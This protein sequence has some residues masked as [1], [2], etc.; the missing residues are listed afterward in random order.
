MFSAVDREQEAR[1]LG[2][3]YG[4][5]LAAALLLASRRPGADRALT[6]QMTQIVLREID[7]AVRKLRSGDFPAG[8]T[9]IYERGAKEGVRDM[10]LQTRAV[11]A[12][13]ANRAA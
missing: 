6:R 11:A 9:A 4:H 2:R 7:A 10:L 12:P 8:L 3:E 1:R 5:E 13:D